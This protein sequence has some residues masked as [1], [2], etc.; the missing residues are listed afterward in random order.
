[1]FN[2]SYKRCAHVLFTDLIAKYDQFNGKLSK[3][4]HCTASRRGGRKDKL[5]ILKHLN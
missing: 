2:V 5:D 1:M 3:Y 4:H